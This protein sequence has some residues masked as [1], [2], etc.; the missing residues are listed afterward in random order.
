M[1]QV[2]VLPYKRIFLIR[3][4]LCASVIATEDAFLFEL[5]NDTQGTDTVA[6]RYTYIFRHEAV[7][8][9]G[10]DRHLVPFNRVAFL[11]DDRL[12][13]LLDRGDIDL[14]IDRA[15]A[16]SA[17]HV[18]LN[19]V[20]VQRIRR[21]AGL[22]IHLSV[23]FLRCT[24]AHIVAFCGFWCAVNGQTEAVDT[25]G[26]IDGMVSVLVLPGLASLV[27]Q[28][29]V[30]MILRTFEPVERQVFLAYCGVL[31]EE[32]SRIDQKNQLLLVGAGTFGRRDMVIGTGSRE[33]RVAAAVR[34][35]I[36]PFVR[37]LGISYLH[38]VG[39][40]EGCV[41]MKEDLYDRVATVHGRKVRDEGGIRPVLF[42]LIPDR[43]SCTA[44]V[45][46]AYDGIF[47]TLANSQ[48]EREDRVDIIRA[49]L[50]DGVYIRPA[51][52]VLFS[53]PLVGISV[54]DGILSGVEVGLW[55]SSSHSHA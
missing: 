25:V 32:V 45:Q 14:Y 39:Q 55:S 54:A 29:V 28:G 16:D 33:D 27:L 50:I 20:P 12:G 17:V 42:P 22:A 46:M 4:N 31:L 36:S 44:G 10:S 34:Q 11:Q 8:A 2:R 23:D 15:V 38:R 48:F 7:F 26:I 24:F 6:S 19:G 35:T 52:H 9:A 3:M 5:L 13:M 53:T 21:H 51:C 47:I 18:H 43:R 40:K 41:E 1:C 37:H 30:D 49:G